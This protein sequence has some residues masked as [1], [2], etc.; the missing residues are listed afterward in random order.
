MDTQNRTAV[1]ITQEPWLRYID[2]ELSDEVLEVDKV[3]LNLIKALLEAP[4]HGGTTARDTAHQIQACYTAY[5]W[6][7]TIAGR[8]GPIR[9]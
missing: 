9:E 1:P 7:T 2:E 5:T 6:L 8:S 3:I 4:L